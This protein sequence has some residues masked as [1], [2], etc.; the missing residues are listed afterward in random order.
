MFPNLKAEMARYNITC[1]KI[2]DVVGKSSTWVES[3]LQGK[4]ILPIGDALKIQSALFPNLSLNYLFANEPLECN[5]EKETAGDK[6]N[7]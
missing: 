1:A 5:I 2:G 3:R 7:Y 6:R 4:T